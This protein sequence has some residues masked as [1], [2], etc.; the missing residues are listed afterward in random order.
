MAKLRFD[1]R[2]VWRSVRARPA[3]TLAASVVLSLGIG[4]TAAM[5]ALTDPFLLKPLPYRDPNGLVMISLRHVWGESAQSGQ[6]SAGAPTLAEWRAR[7]ELFDAVAAYRLNAPSRYRSGDRTVALS[8]AEV[9]ENFFDVLGL[10]D[11][12]LAEW[13]AGAVTG[14]HRLALTADAIDRLFAGDGTAA[15]GLQGGE[16]PAWVTVLLARSFV[17][18]RAHARGQ[19]DALRAVRADTLVEIQS[20]PSG[21]A[22]ASRSF[23][24]LA[25]LRAGVT[26][27]AA[28]IALTADLADRRWD[29]AIEPLPRHMTGRVR[30]IAVGA[31]AAAALILCVCIGNVA[32]LLVVQR[33]SRLAEFA[34]REALGASSADLI[35]LGFI[36]TLLLAAGGV[37]G[38]LIGA[39]IFLAASASLLP[40]EYAA[41]GDPAI[42]TRVVAVAGGLGLLVAL[43]GFV[44]PPCRHLVDLH[45]H[46]T[47]EDRRV[48]WSRM[49]VVAGQSAMTMVLIGGAALLVRSHINLVSQEVGLSGDTLVVSASYPADRN[50]A[51]LQADIEQTL[52]KVRLIPGVVTA[53]A[54]YGGMVDPSRTFTLVQVLG[55]YAPAY[56][57]PVTGSYFDAVGTP[58]LTGR[59]FGPADTS[60]PVV[61]VNESF[62]RRHWTTATAVG[63]VIGTESS[64][65]I[66]VVRDS[67][68]IALDAAPEPTIFRLLD[69]PG[70]DCIGYCEGRLHYVLKAAA[71]TP[72]P[73]ARVGREIRIVNADAILMPASTVAQRLTSSIADRSFATL[74]LVFFSVVSLTVCSAGLAG[75]V[76]ATVARRT[77]EIAIRKVFGASPRFVLQAVLR[78][79]GIAAASGMILGLLASRA[80]STTLEHLLYEVRAGDWPTLGAAAVLMLAIALLTALVPAER[81]MRLNPA[82]ALRKD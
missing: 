61:I 31:L 13:K 43:L 80:A 18:P 8:V 82:D 23:T 20:S 49:A 21:T 11:V 22:V 53:A 29:V 41:L 51:A 10:T 26:V 50:G 47:T 54:V 69:N 74:L 78:D 39:R 40:P 37:F 24:V 66:G 30:L 48:R 6:P 36:E 14:E 56:V 76:G 57:R 52:D 1:L 67:F 28:R 3:A 60:Q 79:T 19:V 64:E 33:S 38:G 63:R 4:F 58:L 70:A 44:P 35:R 46:T 73:S 42:T 71:G 9:T 12:Q 81:A 27:D 68:D 62:A 16:R 34:T 59:G 32:N 5:F 55:R 72:I 75:V 15:A 65:I 2:C 25:R 7:R 77:R 45:G 17:F